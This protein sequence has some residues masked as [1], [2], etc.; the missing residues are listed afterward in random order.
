VDSCASASTFSNAISD[1][2]VSF[3]L[4][5][6]FQPL[7]NTMAATIAAPKIF[8]LFIFFLFEIYNIPPLSEH[9]G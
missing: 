9:Y 1:K 4:R 7:A 6:I 5:L 2:V 3:I 8:F